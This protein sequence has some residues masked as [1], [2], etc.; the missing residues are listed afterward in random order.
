MRP[1]MDM[2]LPCNLL[3]V[4]HSPKSSIA[5]CQFLLNF[6]P[7]DYRFTRGKYPDISDFIISKR[8]IKFKEN[9]FQISNKFWSR[10]RTFGTPRA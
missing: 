9:F 6:Y 4:R 8:I 10:S 2:T 7:Q 1:T 3:W 5:F